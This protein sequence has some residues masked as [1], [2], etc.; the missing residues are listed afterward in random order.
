MKNLKNFYNN[1]NKKG[2]EYND[3]DIYINEN[4]KKN[5]VKQ[6]LIY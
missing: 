5:K 6:I 2:K 3:K 1:I 4:T